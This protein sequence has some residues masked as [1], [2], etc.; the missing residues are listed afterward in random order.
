MR[1]RG[2]TIKGRVGG[3]LKQKVEFVTSLDGRSF[4][5][6]MNDKID[7]VVF[8]ALGNPNGAD[9]MAFLENITLRTVLPVTATDT[10]RCDLEGQ[11]RL[12][13]MLKQRLK[14]ATEKG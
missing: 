4:P 1:E 11:R 2:Q 10:E 5:A 6:P 9:L 3:G 13:A 14:R 7:R 8:L 12:V